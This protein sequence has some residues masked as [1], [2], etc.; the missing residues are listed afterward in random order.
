MIKAGSLFYALIISLLISIISSSLILFAYLTTIEFDNFEISK[1]LKLN[2]DSGLN[3]LLSNQSIIPPNDERT[4]DLYSQGI[5]SVFLKRKYW[6]AYEIIISSATFKNL[7]E[8]KMAQVGYVVDSS[9]N[10][11]LYL[12]D[13][14]KPL[15]ICGKT[16][17]KGV[18]YLPKSGVKR[19]QIEGQVFFGN[20]LIDGV[21]KKSKQTLPKVNQK[22]IDNLT[23][24]VMGKFSTSY[25]S[26]FNIGSNL[27]GDSI[28]NDFTSKTLVFKSDDAIRVANG[29][30]IGN[31]I[32]YSRKQI[33]ISNSAQIESCIL[34]APKIILEEK[35][36]GCVQT[37][38]S[39][40]I[41]I[42]EDV[43]LRY[44]SC[45]GLIQGISSKK[46]AGIKLMENDTIGGNVFAVS[47][48]YNLS[49]PI[50][51]LISEKTIVNG[52]VFSDGYVDL[53]GSIYGSLAVNRIIL[54]TP[55]SVYEN[56]LLNA[57]IDFSK[58]SRHFVGI[59]LIEESNRKEIVKWLE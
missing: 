25:D 28:K 52:K 26:I 3:L 46:M 12:C 4:I 45:I 43:K 22:L 37:F 16:I 8:I 27:S 36:K 11:S 24:Y 58:L 32:I 31:I 10:Y 29:S 7:H 5:D 38:A 15:S 53:K 17:I 14:N 39:D 42:E 59:D 40:S 54:N 20:T 55:S 30:Y 19:A 44:P 49:D 13:E 41:I 47:K 6:G 56:H 1:R 35:F 34:I 57:E 21:I 48:A 50:G 2:V 23:N 9:E 33:S 51:I 18:A